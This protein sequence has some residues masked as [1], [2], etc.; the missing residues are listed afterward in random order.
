[1][2][3]PVKWFVLALV[4]VTLAAPGQVADNGGPR[5]ISGQVVNSVTGQ[6]VARALVQI[7]ARFGMLTDHEGRFSFD[8][9]PEEAGLAIASKPGYLSPATSLTKV[10]Q[11]LLLKLI[12]EAILSGT[13]TDPLGRPVQGLHVQLK[14][15]QVRNGLRNWQQVESTTTSV[16]GEY[17]FAE[18]Q[19][20]KYRVVTSPKVDG[21]PEAES[22][23][24]FMPAT[25]PPAEGDANSNAITMAAGDHAE[26]N[27]IPAAE[28]SYSVTGFVHGSARHPIGI[29]AE[30]PEGEP[31]SAG[32]RFNQETGAFRL[33]LPS[34]SYRLIARGFTQTTQLA[35]ARDI[36][37]DHAPL[38]GVS[39]SLEPQITIPVEVNYQVVATNAQHEQPNAPSNLYLTLEN[40]DPDSPMR[41]FSSESLREPGRARVVEPDGPQVIRNVEPGRYV[42]RGA[43]SFP[44]YLASASCDNL[45]LMRNPLVVSAGVGSCTIRAVVRN[46]PST[47]RWSV[48][49][50]DAV[51]LNGVV[52]VSM[53]SLDNLAVSVQSMGAS[54]TP[55]GS[56]LEG[57]FSNLGPGRYLVFAQAHQEELP[58][59]DPEAMKTLR[60]L[61]QEVTVPMN[62]QVEVQLQPAAEQP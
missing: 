53:V 55:V 23:V 10:T 8:D 31:I 2:G 44:W 6:P 20:G 5:A 42:L 57:M 48:S 52:F 41:S 4:F 36:T 59:R 27:L 33:L 13:V 46:D 56:P 29:Y 32:Q 35:G 12:P 17:R 7:G 28:R 1:M 18:L 19:A 54:S 60:A 21:L 50:A 47:L 11:P 25:Y 3:A 16:E 14:K 9:V 49:A 40:A 43:T 38:E 51:R 22:S 30:T 45:D 24:T 39:L 58:Y 26:A 61:G 34:G 62:G 15:L 37:V